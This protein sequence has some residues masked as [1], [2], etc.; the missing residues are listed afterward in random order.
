[1]A[2]LSPFPVTFSSNFKR[3]EFSERKLAILEIHDQM[4]TIGA[5]VFSLYFDSVAGCEALSAHLEEWTRQRKDALRKAGMLTDEGIWDDLKSFPVHP[6]H[7]HKPQFDEFTHTL[8]DYESRLKPDGRNA[9]LIGNYLVI[10]LYQHW[11]D[12]WRSRIAEALGV[13]DKNLIRSDFWGDLRLYRISLIHHRGIAD[14]QVEKKTVHF[15]WFKKGEHILMDKPKIQAI[16]AGF[17]THLYD[18]LLE[19][20]K[21]L[22]TK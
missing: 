16:V 7:G 17:F 6:P 11:E 14:D 22:C 4:R 9:L 20:E 19:Y 5:E 10:A 1:M 2:T 8:S 21:K 13:E 3:D 12:S 18:E 15:K